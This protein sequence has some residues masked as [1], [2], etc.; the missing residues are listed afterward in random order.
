MCQV[1]NTTVTLR[2]ESDKSGDQ[3]RSRDVGNRERVGT[4]PLTEVDI[5]LGT[6]SRADVTQINA[7]IMRGIENPGDVEEDERN[8]CD[9]GGLYQVS[10]DGLDEDDV[11]VDESEAE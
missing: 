8:D 6:I 7:S 2:I 3:K 9:H 5:T 10:D 4:T 11:G 1:C